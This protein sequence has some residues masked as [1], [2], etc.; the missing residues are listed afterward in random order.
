MIA[1]GKTESILSTANTAVNVHSVA[2]KA[3]PV[4][5]ALITVVGGTL[6]GA[7]LTC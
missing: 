4:L 6:F 3:S 5:T 1:E 2:L 7:W